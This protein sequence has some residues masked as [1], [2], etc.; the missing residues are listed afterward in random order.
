MS[1]VIGYKFN[2]IE[3]T[4]QRCGKVAVGKSK[5]RKYCD[6]CK[7]WLHLDSC[8]KNKQAE[9]ERDRDSL[10]VIA[11]PVKPIE[12]PTYTLAEVNAA[13]RKHGM[14]YGNY[15]CAWENGTVEPPEKKPE[16]KKRG[17]KRD[18]D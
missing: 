17:R 12:K 7:Y 6:D 5:M 8:K 16:K 9:Q 10:T 18:S 4:C 13:A 15:V 14:T 1:N 3:F 2:F 11:T